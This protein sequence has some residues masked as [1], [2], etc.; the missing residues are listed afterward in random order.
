[1]NT[2]A[3]TWTLSDAPTSRRILL[4]DT[5]PESHALI[6]HLVGVAVPNARLGYFDASKGL[7]DDKVN[8]SRYDLIFL[9]LSTD[10]DRRIAWLTRK[11]EHQVDPAVVVLTNIDDPVLDR[12]AQAAGAVDNLSRR[13]MSVS[14]FADRIRAGWESETRRALDEV[15]HCVE[16][17]KASKAEGGETLSDRL[18]QIIDKAALAGPVLPEVPGY[19]VLKEVGRGGMASA[20]L[21]NRNED[22]LPVIL[23]VL[24][25]NDAEEAVVLRRFLREFRLAAKLQHPHIVKIYERAFASDF[26]YIAM[27]YCSGGDLSEKIRAG[28]DV[29]NAVFNARCLASALGAAHAQG[30]I[31]RDVKPANVLFRSDGALVLTDFGIAKTR[32]A[33]VSLTKTNALLGTPHYICPELICGSKVDHRA[34]LYSLGVLLFEMLTGERPYKAERLMKLLDAHMNSSVPKLPN[35]HARF[36][37]LLNTLMAKSP[38]DR[39]QSASEFIQALDAL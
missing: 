12:R 28:M 39:Y 15:L 5:S 6:R 27:E 26:A 22:G 18:H 7:P 20:L 11:H 32:E 10:V 36:Q 17:D 35:E 1:M 38:D 13:D 31:H 25:V 24:R 23:K 19:D 30:V 34:D 4:I 8:L 2:Q 29:D 9:D 16:S 37:P 21:A 14:A 33:A 3:Q